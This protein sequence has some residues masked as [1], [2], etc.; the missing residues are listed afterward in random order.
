MKRE[1]WTSNSVCDVSSLFGTVEFVELV[2]DSDGARDA[3]DPTSLWCCKMS[4]KDSTQKIGTGKKNKK[5]K[6]ELKHQGM[7]KARRTVLNQILRSGTE[8]GR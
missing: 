3:K 6:D 1:I 8:A 5:I 2:D 4:A 7:I